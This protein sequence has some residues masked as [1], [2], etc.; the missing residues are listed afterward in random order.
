MLDIVEKM[1]VNVFEDGEYLKS[2]ELQSYNGSKLEG[3][4]LNVDKVYYHLLYYRLV[5]R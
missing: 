5:N 3:H 1:R 2:A 4:F